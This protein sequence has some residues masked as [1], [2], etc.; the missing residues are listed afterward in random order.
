MRKSV[1]GIC[2]SLVVAIVLLAAFVPGC[3]PTP[4]TGTLVVQA[5]LCGNPWPPQGTGAV[6][7]TL[8]PTGG[9]PV[10]GTAVPTTHSNMTATTWTCAHVSGGPAGAFL[11]SIK[12]SASQSLVAG[13]TITFTLDFEL[14][15]DA[16]IKFVTWTVN[17]LVW[18]SPTMIEAVPCQI[19]DTHFKQWV[20]GCDGYNV[21]MNETSWLQITQ[22]GGPPGVVIYV[23]DDLCAV[24]KT[25]AP[26][27]LPPVKVSQVPSFNGT[28]TLKGLNK[29]LLPG[30]PLVLD[31]HTQW[32]LVKGV[33]YTKN[34]NWFGIWFGHYEPMLHNC[35]LFELVVPAP[36]AV[37]TFNITTGANVTLIGS[38]DVNLANNQ[39]M[40]PPATL[41]VNVP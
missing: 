30:I 8:T 18:Q 22:T 29:T 20:K 24:N 35:T 13:G 23:V 32:Q 28:P 38:T 41:V 36:A 3:T 6:N 7:Y 12:P 10:S 33:N 21:T 27:G 5:T 14:N 34:I 16:V 9:S 26:Q 15:Q 1:F 25:P 17:G 11:K 4:T 2:L 31:V 19:I 40:S 37:Y 39:D